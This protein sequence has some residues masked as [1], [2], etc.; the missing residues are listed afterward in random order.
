MSQ[1]DSV[2]AAPFHSS[3]LRP[4]KL[5][6]LSP[7]LI[8]GLDFKCLYRHYHRIVLG[9]KPFEGE[10]QIARVIFELGKNKLEICISASSLPK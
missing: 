4:R 2:L 8:N 3:T 9:E 10:S 1:Q 5:H 7:N 6:Y